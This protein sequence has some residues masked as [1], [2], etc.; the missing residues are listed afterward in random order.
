MQSK[1]IDSEIIKGYNIFFGKEKVRYRDTQ[2]PKETYFLETLQES[3]GNR[4]N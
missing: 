4:D 2:R 1:K 3:K